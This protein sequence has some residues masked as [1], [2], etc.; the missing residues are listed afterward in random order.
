[1]SSYLYRLGRDVYRARREDYDW[2]YN[3]YAHLGKFE[4]VDGSCT[5][6]DVLNATDFVVLANPGYPDPFGGGAS[7]QVLPASRY[8]FADELVMP[9]RS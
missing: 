3:P 5:I 9:V 6:F 8:V 2:S 1:M 7:Q 4:W